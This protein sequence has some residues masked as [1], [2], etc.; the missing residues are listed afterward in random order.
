MKQTQKKK[1]LK[2]D[3]QDAM[4]AYQECDN[5]KLQIELGLMSLIKCNNFYFSIILSLVIA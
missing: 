3:G 2:F 4:K 1:R 5:D